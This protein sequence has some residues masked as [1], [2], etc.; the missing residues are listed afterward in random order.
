MTRACYART[1][2]G[3]SFSSFAHQACDLALPSRS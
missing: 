1:S 3:N 2:Y